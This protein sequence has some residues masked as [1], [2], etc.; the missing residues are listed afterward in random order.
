MGFLDTDRKVLVV[1]KEL[2]RE[3]A[4]VVQEKES[5]ET[6]GSNPGGVAGQKTRKNITRRS[7]TVQSKG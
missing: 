4:V 7:R 1:D 3:K 6:P 2:A 5:A